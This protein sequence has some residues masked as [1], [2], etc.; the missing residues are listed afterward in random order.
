MLSRRI[1]FGSQYEAGRPRSGGLSEGLMADGV[2]AVEAGVGDV[3]WQAEC[4]RAEKGHLTLLQ[5]LTPTN[6]NSESYEDYIKPFCTTCSDLIASPEAT[7][8]N[9][10][11]TH[12]IV[13]LGTKFPA[14]EPLVDLLEPYPNHGG[15]DTSLGRKLEK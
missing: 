14:H 8:P 1:L 13:T 2:T 5:Q 4:Q 7:P 9:G 10:S 12:N 6:T 11:F 3:P 15:N